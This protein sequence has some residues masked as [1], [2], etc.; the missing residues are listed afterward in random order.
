MNEDKYLHIVQGHF[1]VKLWKL[2]D[3]VSD[4]YKLITIVVR[5]SPS[6]KGSRSSTQKSSQANCLHPL[7]AKPE[8]LS[9][10]LI[11]LHNPGLGTF[12]RDNSF[13]CDCFSFSE[14]KDCLNLFFP[15]RLPKIS[16]FYTQAPLLL[17]V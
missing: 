10:W 14:K 8:L 12:L 4:G 13:L 6:C 3:S 5:L 16:S 2:E 15:C 9:P 1:V 17:H 11:K 7:P